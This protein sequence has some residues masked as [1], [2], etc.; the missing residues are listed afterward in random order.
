ML[1]PQYLEE[2]DKNKVLK[3]YEELNTKV[4]SEIITRVSRI[5]MLDDYTEERLR[6][7][8]EN[9]ALD[10]FNKVLNQF[11]QLDKD[12]K[13]QLMELY[14]D[15]AKKDIQGYKDLYEYND[16]P[17]KLTN[18]QLKILNGGVLSTLRELNSYNSNLSYNC[19]EIFKDAIL[20]AYTE[21]ATGSSTYDKAVYDAYKTISENGISFSDKNGHNIS[22]D[23]LV[24]RIIRKDVQDTA[25]SINRDIEEELGCDGYETTAH[26]GARPSHQ[27]WQGKQFALTKEDAK[28]YGVWLWDDYKDELNDYNC[29][30]SYFGIILGISKPVYKSKQLKKIN[31]ATVKIGGKEMSYY[32]GTQY[33][34]GIERNIR[35]TKQAIDSIK[36][37]K[38]IKNDSNLQQLLKDKQKTLRYYN[39]KYKK[40]SKQ[41]GISMNQP[42]LKI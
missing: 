20:K 34:R 39:A 30:H 10:I 35:K 16:L 5:G 40:V 19:S 22:L 13:E 18:S 37:S 1:T 6:I 25:N 24:R 42:R 32:D 2:L 12:L 31:N 36:N 3:I 41:S 17:F 29:R 23:S 28:K 38:E 14:K 33:M 7:I 8:V 11:S 9:E 27:V 4:S 15:M 21:V 26:L